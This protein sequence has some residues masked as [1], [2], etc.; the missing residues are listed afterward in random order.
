MRRIVLSA[1]SLSLFAA[2]VFA[3]HSDIA[4]RS[5]A[6]AVAD[7]YT[8]GY[9]ER[10]EEGTKADVGQVLIIAAGK[11]YYVPSKGSSVV[12]SVYHRM[13]ERK[14]VFWEE[15]ARCLKGGDITINIQSGAAATD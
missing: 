1:F 6:Q 10:A 2:P 14:R 4:C 11:K 12:T 9:L 8:A 5:Y 3:D 7:E 13:V 15:Y